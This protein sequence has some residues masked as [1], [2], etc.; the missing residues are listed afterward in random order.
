MCTVPG[1]KCITSKLPVN[2]PY[3]KQKKNSILVLLKGEGNRVLGS[4]LGWAAFRE[5]EEAGPRSYQRKGRGCAQWSDSPPLPPGERAPPLA[6]MGDTLE[7]GTGTS[8]ASEHPLCS[9]TDGSIWQ[10]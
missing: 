2:Y 5:E 10:V 1:I 8:S 6:P 4:C 7:F 3:N 9:S